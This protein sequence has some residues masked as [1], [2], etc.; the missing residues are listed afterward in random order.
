M[1]EFLKYIKYK[2]TAK[3]K[4][5]YGVH[6]PFLYHFVRELLYGNQYFYAFDDIYELRL[7][8]LD[9]KEKIEVKDFVAA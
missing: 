6:S 8:L 5:G 1:H 7:D 3:Y 4:K 2:L 9:C